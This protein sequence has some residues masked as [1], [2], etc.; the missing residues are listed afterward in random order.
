M[1]KGF[2]YTIIPLFLVVFCAMS[3]SSTKFVPDGSYLLNDVRIHTDNKKVKP[4]TLYTYVR[5]NANSKWF[6]TIKTQL[7]IY[8]MSGRD[9]TRWYNKF[10]RRIGDEPVIYNAALAERSAT[11]INKAVQ[12]L[13][14]MGARVTIE[15]RINKKKLNLI[16]EVQTGRP[17]TIRSVKRNIG[18][19][20]IA[21]YLQVDSAATLLRN[22]MLFDV[23]VL[24]A[25]RQRI[26]NLLLQNGY[27]KFNKDYI[28]YVADTVRNTYKV[29]LTMQL[30]PYRKS[31]TDTA[32]L[33][34]PQYRIGHVSILTDYDIT[35]PAELNHFNDSLRIQQV[36]IFYDD[37]LFLRPKVLL[38]NLFLRSGA[39]YNERNVQN[40]YSNFGRLSALKYS[41]IRFTEREEKDSMLLD[42]Q[43]LLT[44]SKRHSISFELEGTNSAG[45]FGAAAAISYQNRNLFRGSELFTMKVRGAY[46]AISG[47]T[48]NSPYHNYTEYGVEA[49]VNFP[50]FMFPFLA[51]DFRRKIRAS[52]EFGLQYNYQIRPEFSRM[53]ASASWSY[54][55]SVRQRIQ[56]RFDLLDI[57]YLYTP[58]ISPEF[59]DL[60]KENYILEYNYKNRLI[61]RMGYTYSYNS[62]GADLSNN[63][64]ASNSYSI[65]AGIESA[66]NLLYGIAKMTGLPK[67]EDGEY[68]V[69]NIPFA[70][71]VKGDFDFAKNIVLD[72]RNSLAYHFN[73]GLAFPYGN[74]KI[75]PFE[76]RYFAGGANSV[77]GWAVRSLGPG[78]F[79]GDGNFLNQS[80]DM[81]LLAN[82][83]LRTK[84]FLGFQGALFVDAGNIWTLY[85][86][87]DDQ[88]GGQFKFNSFYKQI[89]VAYGLGLRL[90]LGF[91]IIRADGGMKAID[92]SCPSGKEHYPIF[93]PRFSRDF[94]LHFAVGYPF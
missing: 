20:R 61:M 4:S 60:Y 37:R 8:N 9:S 55:W 15:K 76:K 89:A 50:R 88:P 80:G 45:D 27:F 35:R 79:K 3:C 24:D 19:E 59:E 85:N 87:P 11:E 63:T 33:P 75:L 91:F 66:G 90:D 68:M 74:K 38:A 32:S 71:Y 73:L 44:R 81:K 82:I 52:S 2:L 10:L 51:S 12:N 23:N 31:A 93:H 25:E 64:V 28:T 70:Q 17:Y 1:N 83:E 58:W 13:G 46:E 6:S 72:E 18:D 62:I 94:A 42:V 5:Q 48:Q 78:S 21:Q 43:T 16:Y 92:P 14:Y 39:L 69:L 47:L 67:N 86:Y 84:L 36:S 29:D 34:H 30:L 26:T 57:N 53:V 54:R 77:R 22:G 56:H 49:N 65:R 41:N 40:S 7:Y